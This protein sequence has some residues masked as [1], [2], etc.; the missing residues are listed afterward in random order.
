MNTKKLLLTTISV[1][2]I[3]ILIHAQLPSYVPT[4]GLVAWYPFNGN[5]NDESGNGNNGTVNG[6]T[7]TADRNGSA[8]KAYSFNGNNITTSYSGISGNGA[9]TIS[10]WYNLSKN[11]SQT[12]M[13]V[14]ISYG[15]SGVAGGGWW[16]SILQNQPLIAISNSYAIY[17]A[18]ANINSWYFY[19]VTYDQ[20]NGSNVL[21]TRV[22]INGLLQTSK[23]LTHNTGITINTGKIYPLT[24]GSAGNVA[25]SPLNY[26]YGKLDDIGIWSRALTQVE[27]TKLFN[28][29]TTSAIEAINKVDIKVY[30]NPASTIINLET[31][32]PFINADYI[33]TDLLGKTILSGKILNENTTIE[34]ENLSKGMYLLNVGGDVKKQTFKIVKE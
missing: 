5:A 6:A 16:C 1:L 8:N 25:N 17:D 21:S 29:S 28:S 33:L 10:F 31:N 13:A 22:Y 24:I 15:E 2:C 32:T 23:T 14:M 26:F 9:R 27:I 34:I 3:T 11:S 20:S 30:P 12:E 19:C 4:N 7:L 18:S